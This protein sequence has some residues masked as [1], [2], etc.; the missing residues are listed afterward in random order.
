MGF[1][2]LLFFAPNP[3]KLRPSAPKGVK[4]IALRVS[5]F[6]YYCYFC[7]WLGVMHQK[8]IKTEMAKQ[9][10][11]SALA[12]KVARVIEENSRLERQ[13]AAVEADLAR[14][15]SENRS[16]REKLD[17]AERKVALQSL[18]DGFS[19]GGTD[20]ASRKRA[21]A[22]INRLMREIDRCIALMNK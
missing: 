14:L 8:K 20:E 7:D 9:Q 16:L 21:R 1:S 18:G 5:T 17:A 12:E 6:N 19:G 4:K 11:V 13:Y 22:Q 10:I 3:P 2:N 15:R